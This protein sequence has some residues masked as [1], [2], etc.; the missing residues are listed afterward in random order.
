MGWVLPMIK[1]SACVRAVMAVKYYLRPALASGPVCGV[2][3]ETGID[4]EL[5]NV[6]VSADVRVG[7]I[8]HPFTVRLEHYPPGLFPRQFVILSIDIRGP[9]PLYITA[10]IK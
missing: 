7:A 9:Q 8:K 3:D 10:A 1:Q 2:E 4:A 6:T 5:L